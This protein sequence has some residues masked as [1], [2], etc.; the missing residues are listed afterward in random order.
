VVFMPMT[1]VSGIFG[2]N[3]AGL[4]GT[5]AGSSFGWV[6]LLIVAAG[7]LTLGALLYKQRR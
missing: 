1:L 6:M 2:M 7:A 3:V 5:E 4:P